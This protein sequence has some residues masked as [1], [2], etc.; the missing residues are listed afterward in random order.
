MINF[1]HSF[2]TTAYYRKPE[3][4]EIRVTHFPMFCNYPTN[5]KKKRRKTTTSMFMWSSWICINLLNDFHKV[6]LY[7]MASLTS[8]PRKEKKVPSTCQ[9]WH[10][11]QW[12]TVFYVVKK[13]L[14]TLL[15]NEHFN[16]PPHR[17]Q[18]RKICYE[19]ITMLFCFSLGV[20]VLIVII[21]CLES[22]R[23]IVN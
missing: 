22:V 11:F 9:A 13:W 5:S 18:A 15:W 3:I 4:C 19:N 2:S 8:G 1:S 21:P 12:E 20:D 10:C 16:I 6:F 14:I 7:C 23:L 17:F